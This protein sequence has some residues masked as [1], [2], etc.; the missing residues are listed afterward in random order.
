LVRERAQTLNF[1]TTSTGLPVTI[2]GAN[3]YSVSGIATFLAIPAREDFVTNRDE[4]TYQ[5]SLPIK[6]YL[7]V[8]GEVRYQSERGADIT[9]TYRATLERIHVSVAGS[10][11][12]EIHHRF[13]YDASGLFDDGTLGIHGAP[14]L[15]VTYVP[16]RPGLKRFRGTSLHLTAATGVRDQSLAEQIFVGQNPPSPRSRTFDA[17]IDQEIFPRRLSL[18]AGY[19]HN[20][21][22]HETET[23]NL[24]PF[25]L[26]DN[27]AYRT[28][29][30]EATLAYRPASRLLLE[31]GYT[32][33]ASLVEQSSST[34][35]INPAFPNTNIGALTALVGTRPFDRPPGTGF[36]RA[37]YSGRTLSAGL[38]SSFSSSYD[39]ST[40]LYLNKNL[41]LPN[42]N[43]SPGSTSL[44]ADVS[45]RVTAR[46]SVFSEFRNLLNE[47]TIAPIGF[48]SSPFSVRAGVRIRLGRE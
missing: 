22:S 48:L 25:T 7:K 44:D 35:V 23:L 46:A 40:N 15:G 19:F 17:S 2:V 4:G 41:L 31:G 21:F 3:G 42:R 36:A 45:L 24:A 39:E 8:L 34:P 6:S 11:T 1:S 10:I 38:K 5:T 32:Y 47:R 28:Q 18:H 30:L 27:L 16:V 43:L 14:S 12:G 20:Q 29:G 9:P 26:G 33:L 13:F 37:S